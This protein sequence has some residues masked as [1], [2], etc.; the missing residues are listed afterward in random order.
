[1]V[2][3]ELYKGR[4]PDTV[5]M[6]QLDK[7][8]ALGDKTAVARLSLVT[9]AQLDALL[10]LPRENLTALADQLADDLGWLGDV[11]PTVTQEGADALVARLLRQPAVV[12]VLRGL[13]ICAPCWLPVTSTAPSPL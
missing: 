5:D 2:E 13:A 12:P 8:L 1:M 3:L 9:P 7:L 11:L 6:A 10:T 4:A